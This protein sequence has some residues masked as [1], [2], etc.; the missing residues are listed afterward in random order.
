MNVYWGY[1]N[2]GKL[3]MDLYGQY[4]GMTMLYSR[5]KNFYKIKNKIND[6]GVT[7]KGNLWIYR[8]LQKIMYYRDNDKFFSCETKMSDHLKRFHFTPGDSYINPLSKS[9]VDFKDSIKKTNSRG[10]LG[11][12][13][14]MFT[15]EDVKKYTSDDYK[16]RD[17]YSRAFM[18]HCIYLKKYEPIGF[19]M[20]NNN[21]DEIFDDV[22]IVMTMTIDNFGDPVPF[23]S[24]YGTG[25]CE[26]HYLLQQLGKTFLIPP[27][28]L[29]KL[30]KSNNIIPYKSDIFGCLVSHIDSFSHLTHHQYDE[31]V[32][33]IYKKNKKLIWDYL[34]HQLNQP[35]KIAEFLSKNNI[36]YIYFDLDKDN[37]NEIF[38]GDYELD[39]EYTS[40]AHVWEG[41]EDR[42]NQVARIAKEYISL[43]LLPQPYTPTKL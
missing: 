6:R 28:V 4:N 34:D 35:V 13:M 27:N 7:P 30:Q 16:G 12:D 14:F 5:Y 18:Q 31:T 29:D 37:Y 42:Y 11:N 40:H 15:D 32:V 19:E 2:S 21:A 9:Y 36:P 22:D 3:H 20:L 25:V 41:Y 23:G 38:G 39:R 24:Q 33:E 10:A 43:R 26:S 8:D 17:I 1:A